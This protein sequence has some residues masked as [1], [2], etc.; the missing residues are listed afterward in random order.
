VPKVRISYEPTALTAILEGSD[1]FPPTVWIRI[2]QSCM[3]FDSNASVRDHRVELPW[4]AALSAILQIGQMRNEF[5][6][7]MEAVGEA[8]QR[9]RD[10]QAERR[11][12]V[13]ARQNAL[14]TIPE[15]MI[16]TKLAVLGFAKR[17]LTKFQKRDLAKLLSLKNGANFSVPGAGKTTVTFALNLLACPA[18]NT[19]LVV[20][21]KMRLESGP[22]LS[23]NALMAALRELEQSNSSVLMMWLQICWRSI[24]KVIAVSS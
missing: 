6:F 1:D 11:V 15:D 19:L 22:P 8:E 13:A 2:V 17:E 21:P 10:F 7:A 4:I 14:A 9:L 20:A 5:G 16:E 3:Q 24:D 23:T 12:V 18:D